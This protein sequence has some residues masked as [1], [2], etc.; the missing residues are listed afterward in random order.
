[1]IAKKFNFKKIKVFGNARLG[2]ITTS[3]GI[4]DTPTFMPVGTI[5]N[6]KAIFPEN[7]IQVLMKTLFQIIPIEPQ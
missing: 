3:K 6:V 5:A 1:M 2:K 7:I 4:I